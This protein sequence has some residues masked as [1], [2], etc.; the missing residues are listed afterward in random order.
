[1]HT[2][3]LNVL[4]DLTLSINS[5]KIRQAEGKTRGCMFWQLFGFQILTYSELE[6]LILFSLF[7]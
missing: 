3:K 1:M 7:G 6:Q 5:I 2:F 4:N